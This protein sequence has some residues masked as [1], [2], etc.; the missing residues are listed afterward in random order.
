M[1]AGKSPAR[2]TGLP[3][4]VVLEVLHRAQGAAPAVCQGLLVRNAAGELA[5]LDIP[6]EATVSAVASGLA[7]QQQE[8][9]AFFRSTP[10][11]ETPSLER[12]SPWLDLAPLY[13]SVALGVRGV[14]QLRGWRREA[15]Q[16]REVELELDEESGPR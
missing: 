3:R 4:Q 14:L 12:T 5:L 9:L 8:P 13:L 16:L 15:G 7:A 11:T 6:D 10:A 2:A 1:M